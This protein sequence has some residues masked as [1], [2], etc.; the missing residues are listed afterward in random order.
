M[1]KN[2]S[3]PAVQFTPEVVPFIGSLSTSGIAFV[4]LVAAAFLFLGSMLSI[5]HVFMVD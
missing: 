1:E 5:A 2:G 4:S 3:D